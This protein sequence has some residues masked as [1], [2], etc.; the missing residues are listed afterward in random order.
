MKKKIML[1]IAII[2]LNYT[3]AAYA[4]Y[5]IW[6]FEGTISSVSSSD[7]RV[8]TQFPKS[9][10]FT[11]DITVNLNAR[12]TPLSGVANFAGAITSFSFSI[13]QSGYSRVFING[14]NQGVSITPNDPTGDV[15]YFYLPWDIPA[16]QNGS[17]GMLADFFFIDPYG[18]LNTA[19]DLH[20]LASSW[21]FN[22]Y[23][24]AGGGA[25]TIYDPATWASIGSASFTVTQGIVTN[26]THPESPS[27]RL[28]PSILLL[29][30]KGKSQVLP[31]KHSMNPNHI[32]NNIQ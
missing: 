10:N 1:I 17:L 29:L 32:M 15:I 27:P 26:I 9:S 16:A 31:A 18:S 12:Y 4:N 24:Y 14:T 13:P 30:L 3:A 20:A 11:A 23:T 2:A 7:S 6:H 22:N 5:A 25:S 19:H 28:P 21:N 8:H